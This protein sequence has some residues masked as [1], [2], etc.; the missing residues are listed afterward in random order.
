MKSTHACTFFLLIA[1]VLCLP[2][3]PTTTASSPSNYDVQVFYNPSGKVEFS[4]MK[5]SD[6]PA[7]A[8][9]I[10]I[11]PETSEFLI[12]EV[13]NLFTACMSALELNVTSTT[14]ASKNYAITMGTSN[15][16]FF[17]CP[18]HD[19]HCDCLV[20]TRFIT[21]PASSSIA[22]SIT[23]SGSTSPFSSSRSPETSLPRVGR[24]QPTST[25][26]SKISRET[27]P[28]HTS[29]L[30]M[31]R[32]W[33]TPRTNTRIVLR[34]PTQQEHAKCDKE[35]KPRS[36]ELKNTRSYILNLPTKRPWFINDM[37]SMDGHR[38]YQVCIWVWE[39]ELHRMSPHLCA[40]CVAIKKIKTRHRHQMLIWIPEKQLTPTKTRT[41]RLRY[42]RLRSL[43]SFRHRVAS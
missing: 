9:I 7:G 15:M 5:I 14:Q 35:S 10:F 39:D 4:P 12:Y 42:A 27:I 33:K 41:F 25:S 22:A 24:T 18:R 31:P 36:P 20:A 16:I 2:D 13:S 37:R 30:G 40:N 1:L 17:V 8:E 34:L 43:R 32:R 11:A 38:H 28:G 6:V 26:S 29:T 23:T 21:T 19:D 3:S